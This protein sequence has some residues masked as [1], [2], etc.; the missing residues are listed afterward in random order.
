M[1]K[2]WWKEA[3]VYQIYPRSF[4]DSNGDGIGDLKG[5]VSKL[6]YLAELGID[7]IWLSPCYKSP[8]DDN[9]Y[10]ISD[11]C[12]IM[13]EFGTMEDYIELL[14]EA[15]N[16]GI[17]LV[18]DLVVNHSSDEHEWFAE[19]RKSKDN[20]YRDYYIWRDGK[21]GGEPNNWTSFF[22]GSAWEFDE[23]TNQYYLHLFTKKQPDLNWENEEVRHE[24]YDVM[25]YWLDLGCDGFRMDV[26]S[27][28]SKMPGLPD[29]V[30]RPELTG[31]ECYKDGP[32]IHDFFREMNQ[33]VLSKYDCMTVGET[34][35][36]TIEEA[37]RYAGEDGKE[38]NMVFQFEQNNLDFG[39]DQWSHRTVP[40]PELKACFSKW[41]TELN[42]KAWN[43]LYWTN[44]DQPR[45]VS[46]RGNDKEYRKE[47]QKM[48]YTMLMTLQG[49]PY[50]YQGEEIGMTNTYFEKIEE[51][52]DVEI[53]NLW[54]ERVVKG[55]ADP[56]TLF[57]GIQYRAR[58]NARTPI[59]WDDSEN[60]GFTTGRPWLQINQ[61]YKEIN[62]KESIED[63][64]SIFHYMQKLIQMRK[65]NEIAVYG[66]FK[67]YE[68]DNFSLY[69]YER[70]LNNKKLFVILNFSEVEVLF[71]LP[72][73][74]GQYHRNAKLLIRNY[75]EEAPL[76]S[77]KI[78][79][80]EAAV[81]LM[82][83]N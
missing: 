75:K 33:T 18:M 52:D 45:T 55:S 74:L 51:Y 20:K 54:K 27:L 34:P 35:D 3:V 66:D 81:Y 23:N 7:V 14:K 29:G 9:G 44:H 26:C 71:E 63:P 12:N 77:R 24:V 22:S 64:D 70:N 60:A 1:R 36:V 42:G 30:A 73:E 38:L 21:E 43:S 11:Y 49:T 57:E 28:Y 19:S 16:R 39:E 67:E 32:R 82:E 40:L 50:I 56:N 4:K 61:N 53:R 2:T 58:D 37:Q 80:Y 8:N 46:R 76:E 15:H 31:L 72:D 48:L 59:Q 25:K 17:K 41:Q 78:R 79:P 65:G 83:T 13:D 69:L 6:D 62:V 68:K 5:I 10:D 47:S